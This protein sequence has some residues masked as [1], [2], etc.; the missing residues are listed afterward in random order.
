M[1]PGRGSSRNTAIILFSLLLLLVVSFLP[2]QEGLTPQGQ[3]AIAIFAM[4]VLLWMTNAIPLSVTGI[5][6][7]AALP[8]LGVLDADSAYSLFGNSAVFFILGAFILAAAMMKTGLSKR[9][10]L[11]ILSRFDGSP[12]RLIAGVLLTSASMAFIMP[13]HAV[14]A[15][16][17]PVVVGIAESLELEPLRSRYGTLLFL[18]LAWGAIIGGVGTLLGGA[19]NPLAIG[20]LNEYY[21]MKIG[22]FEWMV[23][24][25][26]LVFV[27]LAISYLVLVNFFPIDIADV[28]SAKRVIEEE[29]EHKGRITEAEKKVSFVMAL[30]L[31]SWIFFGHR[32]GL[33]NIALLSSVLLFALRVMDWKDV[34]DYV[35]WGVILMYGGAIAL[36]SALV[37]TGAAQ[38][39]ASLFLLKGPLTPLTFLLALSII[40]KVLTEGISNTATVAMIMPIGFSVGQALGINPVATVFIVALPSGLAFMLPIGTPPN[41][42]A[43]SSG[44]YEISDIV[45]PGLILNIVSWIVFV[46]MALTY[47]PAI[48]LRLL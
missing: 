27:M 12:S 17:F 35:N 39:L 21:G 45:K 18:S 19:R 43:Y 42:I 11:V 26:P 20:L 2:A 1:T 48:G 7:M 15:I 41:A 38:W 33:A 22:F 14:A 23:A 47:W 25:V 46:I 24:A 3:R 32:L 40:S 10:A 5:L 16:M 37:S 44:Y 28:S 31:F 13:E 36:G 29:L 4:A 30:T 9:T 8:L 6:V 34:E